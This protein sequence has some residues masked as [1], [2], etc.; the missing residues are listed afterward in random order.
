M[1]DGTLMALNNLKTAGGPTDVRRSQ[2]FDR[3]VFMC[4]IKTSELFEPLQFGIACRDVCGSEKVIHG[5][6][7][8]VEKHW[9]KEGFAL[10][11]ID[12]RNVFNLVSRDVLL[13]EVANWFPELLPW[14]SWC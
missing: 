12:F 1:A 13:Q 6:K 4:Q 8:C 10:L 14:A 11:K 5:I 2:T 7:S 3:K 9:D